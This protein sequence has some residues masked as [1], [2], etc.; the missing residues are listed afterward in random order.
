V[1]LTDRWLGAFLDTAERLG[2]L[3]DTAILLTT[4]HGHLFGE[5]GMIASRPRR[6]ATRTLYQ[7]LAHV[8]LLLYTPETRHHGCRRQQLVQPVDLYP[9]FWSCWAGM[10]PGGQAF[11]R[12][13]VRAFRRAI[14]RRRKSMA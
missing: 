10:E 5:H 8:P 9:P 6:T 13:G 12:S 11:G 3:R 7:P 2:T 1:T 14:S 4:D